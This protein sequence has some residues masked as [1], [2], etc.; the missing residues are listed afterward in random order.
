MNEPVIITL[1][2]PAGVGKT[3][4]ARE[5][6]AA[7]GMPYLDTG[8]MFRFLA[9]KAGTENISSQELEKLG[10][11]WSFD[12]EGTGAQT[13]LLANNRPIGE[14]IRT[15]RAGALASVLGKRPEL[16][17]ALLQAQ[18][19]LA[20]KH[21]LVAEGRDL[22]TVVFPDARIKFF[23]DARPE[24]RAMRRWQE[25]ARL[26]RDESLAEIT[27]AIR[28]RDDQDRTRAIAPLKP[29]EDAIV[30]DTSDLAIPQLLEI[31]LSHVNA[32]Q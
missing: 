9:L 12:L 15:E 31:L 13:Q 11:E 24:A 7:L 20:M 18:R 32:G 1:D 14:E 21:S 30:V 22:G 25:Y 17:T 27:E 3:T 29:A 19:S 4:L 23:L 10:R 26:G 2:G 8:A 16:R 28:R 6:A 5:L